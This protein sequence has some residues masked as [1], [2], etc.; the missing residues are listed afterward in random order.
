MAPG[1]LLLRGV[2]FLVAVWLVGMMLLPQV[3]LIS[4]AEAQP[5]HAEAVRSQDQITS[6]TAALRERL[7][8]PLAEG[9]IDFRLLRETVLKRE[10][11]PIFPEDL[12]RYEGKTVRM[13]GF[14]APVD[15]LDDMSNF[16]LFNTPVGCYFCEP[17]SPK[18][19]VFI[20]QAKKD[21][22]HKPAFVA[23]PIEV[24]GTLRLWAADSDDLAH[25]MFLFVIQD[26]KVTA[27]D[28]KKGI[29]KAAPT[30]E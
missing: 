24:E 14:M 27:I 6:G 8:K 29:T 3:P 11:P 9:E 13:A 28:P 20:R 1:A 12:A 23:E 17:P 25:E 22:K 4:R 18:Q 19:V 16:M 2:F 21:P 15:R 10:P 30:G 26:A 7:A 5:G